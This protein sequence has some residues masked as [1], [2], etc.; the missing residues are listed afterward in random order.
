MAWNFLESKK[1]T[2]SDIVTCN[3]DTHT[4]LKYLCK[5]LSVKK[6]RSKRMTEPSH[7]NP[8]AELL[9]SSHFSCLRLR[10]VFVCCCYRTCERA[11]F[12]G[13]HWAVFSGRRCLKCTKNVHNSVS[14]RLVDLL[15]GAR[16]GG[17]PPR[18]E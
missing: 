5:D 3:V 7:Q 17:L 15:T 12:F 2:P 10:C 11:P 13:P 8:V 16:G 18:A 4:H 6:E 14:L 1:C 9:C